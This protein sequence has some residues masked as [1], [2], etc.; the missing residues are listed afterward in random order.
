M[1][2]TD[3]RIYVYPDSSFEDLFKLSNDPLRQL[4][5]EKRI[6][7]Y[8]E[9]YRGFSVTTPTDYLMSN[10]KATA[11]TSNK[12]MRQ[13]SIIHKIIYVKSTQTF[14]YTDIRRSLQTARS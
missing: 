5:Y 1:E 8:C 10:E 6:K 4:A 13:V 2:N 9:E 11:Y 3:F 14:Y 7:D 12:A